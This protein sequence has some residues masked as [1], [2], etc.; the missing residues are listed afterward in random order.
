MNLKL[1]EY[2][3]KMIKMDISWFHGIFSICT[4]S[5]NLHTLWREYFLLFS[6]TYLDLETVQGRIRCIYDKIFL[7]HQLYPQMMT[8]L[9]L[10]Q[11][12]RLSKVPWGSIVRFPKCLQFFFHILIKIWKWFNLNS[13]S[14]F[15]ERKWV[16]PWVMKIRV[17]H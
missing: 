15:E 13:V 16:N 4:N 7:Y 1:H 12:S 10:W 9:K 2:F 11:F 3:V 17:L 8:H 6:Y 5:W 14:T